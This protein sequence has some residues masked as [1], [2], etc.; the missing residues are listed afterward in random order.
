MKVAKEKR[1]GGF[2][3]I[4]L[5]VVIAILGILAGVGTVAYTGYIKAANKGVDKQT[6]GDLMY[7]A[8]LADYANPSLFGEN[9]TAYIAVTG[10]GTKV[11][12]EAYVSAIEDSV[13]DLSGVRLAWD[14][15]NGVPDTSVASTA[16]TN[17][18]KYFDQ[19]YEASY[20]NSVNELWEDVEQYTTN[21]AEAKGLTS[22][23]M[24]EKAAQYAASVDADEVVE[25]WGTPGSSNGTSPGTLI[26]TGTNDMTIGASAA[27]AMA[28]NYSLVEY[29]KSNGYQV[30]DDIF[31]MLKTP[32][33]AA[34]D[35]FQNI[36]WS[37]G[38]SFIETGYRV[39]ITDE[40]WS[41]LQ[42]AVEAYTT[43]DQNGKSQAQA[44]AMAFIALMKSVDSASSG[45]SAVHDP[46][47]PDY[48]DSMKSYVQL[49]G[50]A[51]KKGD[52]GNYVSFE[53]L[54]EVLNFV[55]SSGAV[56]IHV[57]KS[58]GSLNF[59]V[60]PREADPRGDTNGSGGEPEE[61]APAEETTSVSITITDSG[62]ATISQNVIARKTT[63]GNLTISVN[64]NNFIIPEGWKITSATVNSS[65]TSFLAKVITPL[66][67]NY[68]VQFGAKGVAAGTSTTV[69]I[70]FNMEDSSQTQ[71]T[72]VLNG[73]KL[74]A[75]N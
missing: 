8:Q 43:V 48:M 31:D 50:A 68:V 56:L 2:T 23:E 13:G 75:I 46:T 73:I 25:K 54:N 6:V 42:E 38:K 12:S 45:E 57:S 29:M 33:A 51:L 4:E 5:I 55:G 26:A 17:L 74:W 49:A 37:N 66:N 62:T 27:L 1:T 24:L 71:K 19:S 60:N 35:A 58:N 7:A 18:Q 28:R 69:N 15:W 30:S 63:S 65:D 70:T 72:V 21:F 41:T 20:A 59:D 11:V 22:G 3:L 67:G 44:D 52:S 64:N 39:S 32:T 10:N 16:M 36:G 40:E 14:G 53:D 34:G 47:S 61:T 9:G